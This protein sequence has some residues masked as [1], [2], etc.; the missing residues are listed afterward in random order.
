MQNGRNNTPIKKECY[1]HL[2]L[3]T[4]TNNQKN[5]P[6]LTIGEVDFSVHKGALVGDYRSDSLSEKQRDSEFHKMHHQKP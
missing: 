2:L 3:R 6:H 4:E 5:R 1:F